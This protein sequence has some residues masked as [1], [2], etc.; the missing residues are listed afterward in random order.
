[1]NQAQIPTPGEFVELVKRLELKQLRPL[2][3]QAQV[4][5]ATLWNI[6]K[7]TSKNPQLETVHKLWPHLISS[8]KK[9]IS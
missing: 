9:V 6:H 5:Y 7:G 8:A 4:P 3:K 2:A 1:M